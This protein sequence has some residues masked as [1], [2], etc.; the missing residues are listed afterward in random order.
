MSDARRAIISAAGSL[1]AEHGFAATGV[2]QIADAA[3]VN[4][5]MLYYYFRSKAGLYDELI[6]EGMKVISEAV[7]IMEISKDLPIDERLKI[8]LTKYLSLASEQPEL[9][10]IVFRE[11]L[12]LGES[13]RKALAAKVRESAKRLAAVL[14]SARLNGELKKD[15]D[16]SLCAYSI[17]GMANMYILRLIVNKQAFEVGE[18]TNHILDVFMNGSGGRPGVS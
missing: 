3:G 16:T 6:S 13:M 4:K 12:G 2:Q 1:F 5:A 14:E 15:V 18:L 10:R 8:F 11:T 9:A 7:R 17:F